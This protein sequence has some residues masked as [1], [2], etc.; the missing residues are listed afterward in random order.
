MSLCDIPTVSMVIYLINSNITHEIHN[1]PM[2]TVY[3]LQEDLKVPDT[4]EIL[5][6][7]HSTGKR[8]IIP[9]RNILYFTFIESR[10]EYANTKIG[11]F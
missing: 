8:S 11:G 1:T 2:T 4:K 7:T 6:I 10:E 5:I 9:V 3:K